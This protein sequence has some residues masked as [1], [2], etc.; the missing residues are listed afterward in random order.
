MI[1]SPANL[2]AAS[3]SPIILKRISLSRLHSDQ[4]YSPLCCSYEQKFTWPL[5]WN[6][7]PLVG[8]ANTWDSLFEDVGPHLHGCLLDTSQH[9][10]F[11]KA[12]RLTLSRPFYFVTPSFGL[13]TSML[14]CIVKLIET[15]RTMERITKHWAPC[16]LDTKPGI[17]FITYSYRFARS[18]NSNATSLKFTATVMARRVFILAENGL[19]CVGSD[20]PWRGLLLYCA[21]SVE[22]QTRSHMHVDVG[23][24][25]GTAL[26]TEESSL[27]GVETSGTTPLVGIELV[28]KRISK[29]PFQPYESVDSG[30][31]WLYQNL[32]NPCLNNPPYSHCLPLPRAAVSEKT[33]LSSTGR[34]HLTLDLHLG[35][36]R[37]TPRVNLL[38]LSS[39]GSKGVY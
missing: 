4:H 27:H 21:N 39:Y 36:T 22:F 3:T 33:S 29:N 14:G 38:D 12:A 30:S 16:C 10:W 2:L 26:H 18:M 19:A 34:I 5:A 13:A 1:H 35:N 9:L 31:H 23:L 15:S 28:L 11:H 24:L 6:R 8:I 37:D 17:A 20:M 7:E 32:I 25:H